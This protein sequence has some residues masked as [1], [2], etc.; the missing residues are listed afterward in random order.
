[1]RVG[2]DWTYLDGSELKAGIV[3]EECWVSRVEIVVTSL[4]VVGREPDRLGPVWGNEDQFV[5]VLLG[6]LEHPW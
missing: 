3:T 2:G 6:L 5:L 1:M 4:R